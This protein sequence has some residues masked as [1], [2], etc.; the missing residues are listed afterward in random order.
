MST[1]SPETGG[2]IP[3]SIIGGLEINAPL[4]EKSMFNKYGT[5]FFAIEDGSQ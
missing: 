3:L 4:G 5:S 1:Y 2:V